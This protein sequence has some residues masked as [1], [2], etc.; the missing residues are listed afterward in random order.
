M[1]PKDGSHPVIATLVESRILSDTKPQRRST[2]SVEYIYSTPS[3]RSHFLRSPQ[4]TEPLKTRRSLPARSHRTEPRD[5]P[6]AAPSADID[7][8]VSCGRDRTFFHVCL[9]KV[10]D[11]GDSNRAGVARFESP[12]STPTQNKT[13]TTALHPLRTPNQFPLLFT[14]KTPTRRPLCL[15]KGSTLK[16][17]LKTLKRPIWA[18][19]PL[20]LTLIRGTARAP[21]A[22]CVGPGR[23]I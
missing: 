20:Q 9:G 5:P 10:R 11:P 18:R 8:S 16:K 17:N 3:P 7:T 2:S 1:S 14:S 13:S 19:A 15:A 21:N 4:A 12:R 23:L 6:P 22:S